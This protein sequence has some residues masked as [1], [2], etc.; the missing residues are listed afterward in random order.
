MLFSYGENDEDEEED[1]ADENEDGGVL[2]LTLVLVELIKFL[3]LFEF[4]GDVFRLLS[5]PSIFDFFASCSSCN[6]D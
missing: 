1:E 5:F 4:K 6:F 3:L 2:E